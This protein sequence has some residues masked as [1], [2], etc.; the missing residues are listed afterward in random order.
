MRTQ[1]SFTLFVHGADVLS[2]E[3]MDALYEAGCDDATFGSRDGAQY[4]AFDREGTSFSAALATA[5]HDLTNALPGLEIAHVEPDGLVRHLHSAL[6][7][8]RR[9]L[10]SRERG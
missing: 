3:S 2:D 5:I 6:P 4:G 8:E 10:R 9:R 1:F 7:L